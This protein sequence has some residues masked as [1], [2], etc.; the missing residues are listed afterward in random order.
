MSA[1]KL[2][3]TMTEEFPDLSRELVAW[4]LTAYEATVYLYLL[5]RTSPTGGSKIAVGAGLHRPYVYMALPSLIQQGLVVEIA[6]GKQSKYKAMPP[7]FLE[8]LEAKRV[9]ETSLLSRSLERIAKIDFEQDA[10]LFIGREAVVKHQLEWVR[11]AP[12]GVTQYLLGGSGRMLK[13]VFGDDYEENA[14]LQG[15]KGF[16]TFYISGEEEKGIF[17]DYGIHK[18]KLHQRTLSIIPELLPT[19]A[20]RGD[21][22]EIH[23]YFNP[24]I[25]YSI[26]SRDVAE[27]FKQFFMGLWEMAK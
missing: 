14:C 8:K 24:P 25:M 6:H 27:K 10:E 26:K 16:E 4:G 7:S 23:S 17:V 1:P 15:S 9:V 22:V 12:Q 21:T 19:I 18:V 13:E 5:T 20:I 11:N 2:K 3:N